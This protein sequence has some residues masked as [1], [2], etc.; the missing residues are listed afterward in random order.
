MGFVFPE[1]LDKVA[2]EKS[3]NSFGVSSYPPSVCKLF[4]INENLSLKNDYVLHFKTRQ[5]MQE[6]KEIPLG[7]LVHRLCS[8]NMDKGLWLFLKHYERSL[9]FHQNSIQGKFQ[10]K[11]TLHWQIFFCRIFLLFKRYPWG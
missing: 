10:G 11:T 8:T 4:D 2:W 6:I 3:S 7:S 5:K 1:F 9:S